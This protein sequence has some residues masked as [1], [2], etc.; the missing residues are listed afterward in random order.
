MKRL[1][2]LVL[3]CTVM[4]GC[5]NAPGLDI[6]AEAEAL[7]K[8]EDQVATAFKNR[9]TEKILSYAA[10]D[11]MQMAPD[12]PT[13]TGIEAYGRRLE[14]GFADT[15]YLWETYSLNAEF[16]EVS[17]SGDLAYVWGTDLLKK[18][19]PEGIVDDAA[20]WVD[21]WKKTDGRWTVALN[22]WNR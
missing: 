1:L 14:A 22:I 15:I 20:R 2:F 11:I 17:S 5:T 19:T 13:V 12:A 6:A 18:K 8:L 16:I 3:A 7:R 4:A 10:S 21:I 9:D